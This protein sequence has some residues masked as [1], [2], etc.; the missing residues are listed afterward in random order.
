MSISGKDKQVWDK[1]RNC[2]CNDKDCG[3][4][5]HKLCDIKNCNRTI[6]Y[7]SHESQ[8]PNSEFAW[9]IDHITP[10]SKGGT[11]DIWNL[12]AVHVTCNRTKSDN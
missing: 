8:Q 11:N 2:N 9:N 6:L 3:P 7:G 10:I 4:K 1:A 12:Q 5:S